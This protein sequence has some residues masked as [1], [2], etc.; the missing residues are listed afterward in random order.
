MGA[1]CTFSH[2]PVKQ[3]TG[4]RTPK[5]AAAS[6]ATASYYLPQAVFYSVFEVFLRFSLSR[7]TLSEIPL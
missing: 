2:D 4:D 6:A 3:G 1:T 7:Y 5:P